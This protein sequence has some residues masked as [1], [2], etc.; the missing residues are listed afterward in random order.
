MQRIR[1]ESRFLVNFFA[2]RL[3]LRAVCIPLNGHRGHPGVLQVGRGP[4]PSRHRMPP[5]PTGTS[6]PAAETMDGVGFVQDRDS[7]SIGFCLNT[8]TRTHAQTQVHADYSFLSSI[9]RGSY[10]AVNSPALAKKK[11]TQSI[12]NP[13]AF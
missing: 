3:M 7:M 10:G 8:R 11:A 9:M 5:G 2:N 4:G 12:S 6:P 1:R 13:V